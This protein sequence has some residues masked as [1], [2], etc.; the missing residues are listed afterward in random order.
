ML[1]IKL[2][3]YN[4]DEV[5][6]QLT[7]LHARQLPFAISKALNVSGKQVKK[8]IV[9][10]MPKIFHKPVEFTLGSLGFWPGNKANPAVTVGFREWA[11]KGVPAVK[12][13]QATTYG[14]ARRPKKYEVALRRKGILGPNQFTVPD[15]AFRDQYGNI[16]RGDIVK[17]LSSLQ[18]F[19]EAGYKANAA[20]GTFRAREYFAL[21]RDGSHLTI[22]KRVGKSR[23]KYKK[24]EIVPFLHVIDEPRYP[25]IFE[26][27]KIAK[28]EFDRIWLKNFTDALNYAIETARP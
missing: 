26:F 3:A 10:E 15:T 11:S 25:V 27:D 13:L 16:K 28:E 20:I 6:R 1:E 8:H 21:K 9:D 5:K 23:G 2:T 22:Y 12:Y 17:M 7:D 18:A 24:R 19:T 4:Y 14:G